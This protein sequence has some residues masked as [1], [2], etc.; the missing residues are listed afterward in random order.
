MDTQVENGYGGLQLYKQKIIMIL[1]QK[2]N[3]KGHLAYRFTFVLNFAAV[4]DFEKIFVKI[5]CEMYKAKKFI[6]TNQ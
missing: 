4:T 2:R 5:I 6:F 1:R 3:H